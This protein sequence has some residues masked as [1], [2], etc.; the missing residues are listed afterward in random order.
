M[1]LV[2]SV[3]KSGRIK[4][5]IHIYGEVDSVG[6]S[7]L[8]GSFSGSP[9]LPKWPWL[10]GYLK[11]NRMMSHSYAVW[12][13][14]FCHTCGQEPGSVHTLGS[15]LLARITQACLPAVQKLT[16]PWGS[17]TQQSLID[18]SLG[19]NPYVTGI[20]KTRVPASLPPDQYSKPDSFF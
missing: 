15:A 19:A 2:L 4:A 13:A 12:S 5:P 3:A 20:E 14:V 10:I 1:G 16:S 18:F 11:L 9:W 7:N 17:C 8:H 6:N